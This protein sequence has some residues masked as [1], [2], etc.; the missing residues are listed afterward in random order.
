MKLPSFLSHFTRR[1][2]LRQWDR[3]LEAR[4][5]QRRLRRVARSAAARKGWDTRRAHL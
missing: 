2:E 1:A 3:D 5:H 4:L